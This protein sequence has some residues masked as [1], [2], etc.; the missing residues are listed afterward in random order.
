MN[1]VGTLFASSDMRKTF[2]TLITTRKIEVLGFCRI[3]RNFD[4]PFQNLSANTRRP[5]RRYVMNSCTRKKTI[6][7]DIVNISPCKVKCDARKT[8]FIPTL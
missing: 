2:I 4:I 3:R 8:F 1:G 7:S 5:S 6:K